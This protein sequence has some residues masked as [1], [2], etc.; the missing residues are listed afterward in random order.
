M[1][2]PCNSG[3]VMVSTVVGKQMIVNQKSPAGPS[4]NRFQVF[5]GNSMALVETAIYAAL[6][7]CRREF[8]TTDAARRV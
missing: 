2:A 4:E 5:S 6:V 8:V 3:D 1:L 7:A